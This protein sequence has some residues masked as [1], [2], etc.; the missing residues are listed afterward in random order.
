LEAAVAALAD[1]VFGRAFACESALPAADFDVLL[2]EPLDRVFDA[3]VA[4]F[5]PV[6]FP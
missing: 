6:T 5:L 4:A 1:V 3:L 2:V